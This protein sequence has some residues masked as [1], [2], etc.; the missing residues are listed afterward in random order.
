MTSRVRAGALILAVMS[1]FG[2]SKTD[3][4]ASKAPAPPAVPVE[5]AT[6]AQ[7]DAPV[8]IRT[9]GSVQAQAS[10]TLR[11]Q[12]AGRVAEI[13]GE[14]GAEVQAGQVL[15]RLD[16]AWFEAARRQAEADLTQSRAMAADAHNL[17]ERNKSALASAA[18]SQRESEQTEAR[19]QAAD[20]DV[21]AKQAALETAKL[22]TA[23]CTITAPFGGRLGQFQV[24][25]GAIVKENEAN[26][27]DLNQIDPIEVAF[28]VPEQRLP[29]IR[30]AAAKAPLRVEVLP[31]GE[32]GGPVAGELTFVDNKVDTSTGTIRLKA[33]FKNADRRLWPGRFANVTLILGRE[34]DCIMIPDRAVQSTQNGP[35]VFVVKSDQT[36]EL[37][38]ISIRRSVD[39][40]TIVEKGIASGDTVVTDGQLRL[41]PGAS[42]Q[43]KATSPTTAAKS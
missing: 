24:K 30:E 4:A 15:L 2:C 16:P 6:A 28:A 42:V 22:N 34:T 20:A 3:Q 36:V 39:G 32:T 35:S 21:L 25:P 13:L 27:V 31:S 41:A 18:L 37:R 12:V 33:T 10:V 7:S 17:A 8:L 9:I 29:A 40:Q 14:E 19:A 26:L 11:P 1:F 5:V 38:P 23:Y 43:I